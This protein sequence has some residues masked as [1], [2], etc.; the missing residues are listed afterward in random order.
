MTRLHLDP[1]TGTYLLDGRPLDRVTTILRKVLGD[2]TG[3]NAQQWHLDRGSAAHALYAI[4]GRGDDLGLYQYD[5]RLDGHVRCWRDWQ[6]AE[7]VTFIGVEMPVASVKHGYAGTLDALAESPRWPAG[8][9]I[10]DYKQ[11][12][13]R[14]DRIQLAAYA[15]AVEE[16]HGIPVKGVIGLQI[17]GE[18]WRYGERFSGLALR[19][20][21]ADWHAV[22]AVFAMLRDKV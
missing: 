7:A 11:S 16:S 6:A 10:V 19:S 22:R 2:P 13:S 14:R 1:N 5:A 3:G 4:L 17:D 12:A 15:V 21:M 8:T 18:R 9:W 20:A